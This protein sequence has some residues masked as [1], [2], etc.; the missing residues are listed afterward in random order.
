MAIVVMI[1][2]QP[3]QVPQTYLCGGKGKVG[4]GKA[5]SHCLG[6]PG[7]M[8]V[9]HPP[10]LHDRNSKYGRDHVSDPGEQQGC[11]ERTCGSDE[12]V[13]GGAAS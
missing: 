6:L 10:R 8:Q 1:M 12:E 5:V 11:H 13:G 4:G 9:P 2:S 3:L 7:P